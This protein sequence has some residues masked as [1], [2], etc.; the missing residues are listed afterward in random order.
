MRAFVLSGGGAAGAVQFGIAKGLMKGGIIPDKIFGTSAGGLN[1]FAISHMG[2]AAESFWLDVHKESDVFRGNLWVT[3]PFKSGMKTIAPLKKKIQKVA[4]AYKPKIPFEVCILN[5]KTGVKEYYPQNG[6]DLVN[7]VCAGASMEGY[8][9]PY[10]CDHGVYA[11]GGAVENV[12]L[13]KAVGA[14]ANE[15]H[16]ILCWPLNTALVDDWKPGNIINILHRTYKCRQLELLL[17]DIRRCERKNGID[18]C[19]NIR[20]HV[21]APKKEVLDTLDFDN[22]KIKKGIY[23]G[24]LVARRFLEQQQILDP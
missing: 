19:K 8:V 9:E 6:P 24:E 14:G 21:H 7:M 3:Y 18:V 5:L 16:V 23:Q 13:K 4:D 11:D 2:L 1:A 20:L 22:D 15:I 10:V 12:P 17:E